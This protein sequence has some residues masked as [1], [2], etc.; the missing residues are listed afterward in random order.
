[1]N[2]VIPKLSNYKLK[3]SLA[4]IVILFIWISIQGQVNSGYSI[5]VAGHAYGAH[6][7]TN[8]GL[9]QPLMDK[10]HE[11]T[12]ASTAALFLTGDIVNTSTTASWAQVAKELSDLGYPSYYVM[13]NH[14]S[15]STGKAIFKEKHGGAYYSFTIENELFVVLNSTESD[16]SISPVQLQF[17]SDVLQNA[18]TSNQR[19]FIFF[20]EVIWNSHEKYRLVRS[21][22]RSRY[23]LIKNASN[24][25]QKVYPALRAYPQK[26]FYLFAGDVGGNPDAIAAFYDRWENVT[27]F[28]SGMGEVRDENFLEVS[29]LPDTVSF[30]LIPLKEEVKMKSIAWYNVPQK[31]QSIE[32]PVKVSSSELPIKFEVFPVFNATSYRWILN[33]GMS[34]SSDS[35]AID[36][37]FDSN[38]QTGKLMVSAFNDGFGESEP[39]TLNI[40]SSDYTAVGENEVNQGLTVLQN[41]QSMQI[42]Y[43]SEKITNGWIR[44]N[45]LSGSLI[46]SDQFLLHEGMNTK[47]V[48]KDLT[49]KGLLLI[50]LSFENK[51]FSQK[52]VL[53]E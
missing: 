45:N 13:G 44:I 20:H 7:G 32:G 36:L 39:L 2:H 5:L 21:N 15:N 30:K 43:H 14:D 38:F 27:L 51:R 3:R 4:L 46:Y 35:A 28:A 11:R 41:Q 40:Q 24:F 16:R 8:I 17:L 1:M 31:P 33:D 9:H 23:D 26:N 22:S 12:D 49:G 47:V 10:L 34:G 6:A 29:I 48:D 18:A 37:Q 53:Y 25:W 19:V 42:V 50:E 52:M